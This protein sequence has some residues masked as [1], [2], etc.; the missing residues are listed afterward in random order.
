MFALTSR[1]RSLP[2]A[3]HRLPDGRTVTYVRR[4]FLPHPEE[5]TLLREHVVTAGERLDRIAFAE[6][7][8]AELAWQLADANRAV[9]PDELAVTGRRLR[10]TLP[11]TA[12]PG[13]ASL[14]VPGALNG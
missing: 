1:Y 11:A 7:G 5:L 6:L 14:L 2:T 12:G 3:T 13:A 10:I 8:D 4:R 9:D